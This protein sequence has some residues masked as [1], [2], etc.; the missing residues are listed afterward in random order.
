[1]DDAR[2]LNAG[3]NRHDDER[4]LPVGQIETKAFFKCLDPR[5]HVK[6]F[7]G[8]VGD[9]CPVCEKTGWPAGIVAK[10]PDEP[11]DEPD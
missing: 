10:V 8:E 9:Q 4:R 7:P 1:M 3:D 11:V 2:A 6:H 5:C